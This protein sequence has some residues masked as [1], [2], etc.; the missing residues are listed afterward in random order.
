M[1]TVYRCF[2]EDGLFLALG[3]RFRAFSVIND[4][5]FDLRTNFTPKLKTRKDERPTDM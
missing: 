1:K 3:L 4:R 5:P 2:F